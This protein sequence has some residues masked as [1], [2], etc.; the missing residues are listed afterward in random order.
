MRKTM[1]ALL[2]SYRLWF[3][4][5]VLLGLVP[6]IIVAPYTSGSDIPQFAGFADTF[7]E[8]HFHFYAYCD[9]TAWKELGWAYP[10]PYVYGPLFI[11]ILGV[12]RLIAPSPVQRIVMDG[13]YHVYA[14]PDWIIAI[15]AVYIFFDIVSAV[16]IY[17]IVEKYTDNKWKG[18]IAMT[19]Y[20]LNPMVIYISSIYGMF[21]QIPLAFF[22]AGIYVYLYSHRKW[23]GWLLMGISLAIKPLLVYAVLAMLLYHYRSYGFNKLLTAL[24]LVFLP[25][26]V[27]FSPY[28]FA[29]PESLSFLMRAAK[30]VSSPSYS[31]P[32]VYSFNGIFS[33]AFYAWNYVGIN[34]SY[35]LRLWPVL[36]MPLYLLVLYAVWRTRDPLI[37]V[38]ASYIVYTATY[39][40]V[41]HQY[42]VPTVAFASII[43]FAARSKIVKTLATVTGLIAGLWPLLYPISFW[44]KVHIQQPNETV[45]SLLNTVSVN[46]VDPLVYVYYSL[47]LTITEILFVLAVS[48]SLNDTRV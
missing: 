21:D 17:M 8:Y 24:Y 46:T 6:R 26:A 19:L 25:L 43:M 14:P 44:A 39:W 9:A 42:L 20:Y 40:R 32:V 31:V 5:L 12:L 36:F 11:I 28:I 13:S 4:I 18:L 16:L 41:N 30:S 48:F 27:A 45:V 7:L 33:I 34:T 22:L 1:K 38:L 29:E 15:K 35:I 47:L 2:D 10:W 37:P 23:A 3:I